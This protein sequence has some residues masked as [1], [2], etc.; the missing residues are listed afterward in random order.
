MG[1][2]WRETGWRR[3]IV[4]GPVE[5]QGHEPEQSDPRAEAGCPFQ[6]G[7]KERRETRARGHQGRGLVRASQRSQQT[8]ETRAESPRAQTCAWGFRLS[9]DENSTSRRQEIYTCAMV[10]PV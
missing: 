10:V 9:L 7:S 6:D 2:D 4:R 5:R 1:S 8:D 3:Q